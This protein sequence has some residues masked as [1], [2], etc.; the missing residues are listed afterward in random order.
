MFANN[1]LYQC[2]TTKTEDIW[3]EI[4]IEKYLENLGAQNSIVILQG[5]EKSIDLMMVVKTLG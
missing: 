2:N 1:G 3:K 5:L 4:Q